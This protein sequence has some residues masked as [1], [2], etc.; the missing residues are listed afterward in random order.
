MKGR[1]SPILE[2]VLRNPVALNKLRGHYPGKGST[3]I[4]IDGKKYRL[5]TVTLSGEKRNRTK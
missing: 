1:I 3:T 2:K 4:E 5:A